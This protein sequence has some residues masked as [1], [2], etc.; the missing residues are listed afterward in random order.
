VTAVLAAA[1]LLVAALA[2]A[3]ELVLRRMGFGSFPLFEPAERSG[4]RMRPNQA[5]RFRRRH[6]WRYDANG[7][8]NDRTPDS[9]AETTLLVGDSVVDGGLGIGQGETLAALASRCS[10]QAFYTVACHGW[11]LANSLAALTA[12]PGWAGAGRLVFVL[13][14][15][16]LDTVGRAGSQFSFPT[17]RPLWLSVWFVCRKIYRAIEGYLDAK[18]ASRNSPPRLVDRSRDVRANN[19]ADFQALLG[20]YAGPVI[21]VRYQMRGENARLERYF[22]QL[23]SLDPRVQL[24]EAAEAA[25]WS[26]DCYVDHI[27]PN[28]RGLELLAAHLCRG[29][30]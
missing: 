7:M 21:L 1:A 6:A 10:G 4:Y 23:T 18:E 5:G 16:D 19:L 12:L 24:L 13:N 14:T 20:E 25:G 22:E 30:G 28:A 27:H 17:R 3:V 26:N 15:G 8:R 29:L 9:F 11:A 2:L